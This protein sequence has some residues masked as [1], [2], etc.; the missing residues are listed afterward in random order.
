MQPGRK[1]SMSLMTPRALNE[2]ARPLP[3]RDLIDEE[4]E[5]WHSIVEQESP[6]WF[7]NANLPLLAQYCRHVIHAKRIAELIAHTIH[8]AE[9]MP[10]VEEYEKLLKLQS[11]ESRMMVILAT[12]MRLT[13]QSSKHDKA[14]KAETLTQHSPHRLS[15][16]G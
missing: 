9:V 5:V 2:V 16:A 7:T 3:P 10:W 1:S 11:H 13:Q 8:D 4:L 15:I 14:R 12:S 6:D